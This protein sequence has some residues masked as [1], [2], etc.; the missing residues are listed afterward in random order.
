MDLA[1]RLR[2]L[3]EHQLGVVTRRQLLDAD[4]EPG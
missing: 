3:A 1:P 4:V 2:E